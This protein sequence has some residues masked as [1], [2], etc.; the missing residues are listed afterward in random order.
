MNARKGVS[1]DIIAKKVD[2]DL[3]KVHQGPGCQTV[4]CGHLEWL[5]DASQP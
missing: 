5:C 1:E 2:K 3:G 4:K